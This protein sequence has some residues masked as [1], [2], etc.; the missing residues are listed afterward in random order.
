LNRAG[1]HTKKRTDG[2]NRASNPKKNPG[3]NTSAGNG[4]GMVGTPEK[5]APSIAG[6][7][8][9]IPESSVTKLGLML[10]RTENFEI[11]G[12]K[13]L[14]G[15][16]LEIVGLSGETPQGYYSA[17]MGMQEGFSTEG[18]AK[19]KHGSGDAREKAD[20]CSSKIVVLC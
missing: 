11:S 15:A 20:G 3:I 14:A 17:A 2:R 12:R 19:K 6:I 10:D 8:N 13:L 7:N 4:E 16:A 9:A 1:C 5:E 18:S